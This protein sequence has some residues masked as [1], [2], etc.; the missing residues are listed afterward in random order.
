MPKQAPQTALSRKRGKKAATYGDEALEEAAVTARA[1]V[2]DVASTDEEEELKMAESEDNV[3]L[4]SN[5]RLYYAMIGNV[6]PLIDK[7]KIY[8]SK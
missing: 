8:L 1:E 7:W 4:G 5:S 2:W 3:E 6:A